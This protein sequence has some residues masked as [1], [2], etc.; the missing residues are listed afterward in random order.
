MNVTAVILAAGKGARFGGDKV[1]ARLGG[2]PVWRWSFEAYLDHPGV[3]S[4]GIVASSE[5]ISAIRA[6]APEAEFVV[7]GGETR[8]QSSRIAALTASS[9]V[10]LIH[11][12]AR[13]FVSPLVI[14]RVIEAVGRSEA[15]APAVKA[16]DTLRFVSDG[17]LLDREQV[18]G[19]QTPQGALRSRLLEAHAK[20]SDEFT[21]EL[22]LVQAIGLEPELVEGD[23]ANFKITTL[24]DLAKARGIVGFAE[25]RTG[26]GYDIHAFS[27]DPSRPMMLGGVSFDGPGLEGHS[28]ADVLLHAAVDAILGAAGLGDIGVHFPNTDERWRGEPS[29]TFLRH[30][31]ELVRAEGWQIINLDISLLAETPKVMPRASE[32]R[33]TIATALRIESSRVSVKA[34]TNEKLGAIGRSE[35]IAAF[36][37]ATLREAL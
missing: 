18:V 27:A 9:D 20:V 2:K 23:P 22:G 34:T 19:M 3:A 5:N 26:L 8:Q 15:A 24:D 1:L 32:I 11:D 31:A 12:G 13:P 6:L 35:G 10:V 28:D 30:A 17:S 4:V 16:S 21:D 33:T 36:A 29:L 7:E 25:T 37:V 14:D